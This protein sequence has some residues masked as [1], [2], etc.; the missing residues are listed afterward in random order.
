MI[1]V[2]PSIAI[3]ED[4]IQEQFI[5]ASG[6]G[7]QHVQKTE[8]AVQLRFDALHSP[9]LPDEVRAR[10][11][12]LAGRRMSAAGVLIIEAQRFRSQLLNR[13]DALARLLALIVQATERPKTRHQT[14]PTQASRRRRLDGKRRR[15]ET[16]RGRGG[17]VDGN[18]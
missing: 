16:K 8:T 18:E 5:R 9:N 7:G 11:I 4:E 1:Q 2:T 6:P 12:R 13:E 3:G 17:P 10:L 14:K 15:G